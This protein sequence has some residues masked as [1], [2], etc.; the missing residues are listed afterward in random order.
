MRYDEDCAGG[1]MAKE[2]IVANINWTVK[3]TIEEIRRQA[4]NVEKIY[5]IYVVDDSNRL[6]G[7]VSVKKIIL[8]HDIIKIQNIYDED[9]IQVETYMDEE[10][11]AE[12][13]VKYDLD[14]VGSESPR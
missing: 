2:M 1:L 4:E 13:M 10:Q 9:I 6:K 7:K 5:S 14:A 11:V 3:Q 12:V 8:S